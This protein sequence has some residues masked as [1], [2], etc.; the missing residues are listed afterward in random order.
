MNLGIM[1][2]LF[3]V[4]F[5]IGMSIVDMCFVDALRVPLGLL[6]AAISIVLP[7]GLL[8]LLDGFDYGANRRRFRERGQQMVIAET[9]K[10][11]TALREA[12]QAAL[13]G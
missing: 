2:F 1:G 4:L 7:A 13:R 12:Q 11:H 10:H 9:I 6:V 5:F 3:M 8:L